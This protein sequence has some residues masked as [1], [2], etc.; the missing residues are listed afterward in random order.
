MHALKWPINSTRTNRTAKYGLSGCK[1]FPN[2]Y[3]I[4]LPPSSE[5]EGVSWD[6]ASG[7]VTNSSVVPYIKNQYLHPPIESDFKEKLDD[8][9]PGS[10]GLLH[11]VCKWKQ[12]WVP[13]IGS[14][15]KICLKGDPQ[16]GV[17]RE[18]DDWAS[19][20]G[21]AQQMDAPCGETAPGRRDS[22]CLS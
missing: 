12:V 8:R 10:G 4:G 13:R 2:N 6:A 18:Q 17:E 14:I 15:S 5:D 3:I 16:V 22:P 21:V 19:V 1:S 20:W 11:N 9:Y 7:N